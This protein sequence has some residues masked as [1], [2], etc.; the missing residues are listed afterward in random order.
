LILPTTMAAAATAGDLS[1][2]VLQAVQL[3]DVESFG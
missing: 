2:L 3:K 1:I